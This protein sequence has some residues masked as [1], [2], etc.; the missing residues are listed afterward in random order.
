MK[1]CI[2]VCR[3]SGQRKYSYEFMTI[4]DRQTDPPAKVMDTLYVPVKIGDDQPYYWGVFNG[5]AP[6]SSLYFFKSIL[7]ISLNLSTG[8]HNIFEK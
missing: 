2:G 4:L 5:I 7:F 6:L 1:H 3:T 8:L